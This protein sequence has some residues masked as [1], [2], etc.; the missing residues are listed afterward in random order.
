ML[1]ENYLLVLFLFPFFSTLIVALSRHRAAAWVSVAMAFAFFVLTLI[2]FQVHELR[3]SATWFGNLK[4]GL[5][6]DSYSYFLILL[7]A[8]LTLISLFYSVRV[9]K[10]KVAAYHALFHALQATVVGSLLCDDLVFFYIFWEAMLIPMYFIIGIWGGPRRKYATL[11]FFL[12]TFAGSLLMLI[13]LITTYVIYFQQT[14]TWSASFQTLRDYFHM[15]PMNFEIQKWIF[16]SFVLSFAIKIP[17]FPFHT[18]LPDAHV[19][20]PTAGSVILAGVLLKM[21]TYGLMRFAIPLFHES[22]EYFAGALCFLSVV[23]IILGALVAWRQTDIKKLI[24]YSSVSHL[25]F[26]TLGIFMMTEAGWNGA[27]LQMLNHGLSTGALFLLV[28]FLYDQT[29]TRDIQ[30]YG[31]LAKS[32]P[33]FA[34]VTVIIALSSIALPGTN[35]FVGE[36]LIL[37]GSFQSKVASNGW[38]ILAGVGVILGAVYMLHLVQKLLYG[39]SHSEKLKDFGWR[40]WVFYVPLVILVFAIGIFPEWILGPVREKTTAMFNLFSTFAAR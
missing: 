25:G 5:Y 14:G 8:F 23:G 20:A 26:I 27:Y 31:G 7:S 38:V 17:L 33:W 12:F 22:A 34:L 16:L 1:N 19:E 21:G 2:G 37:L 18:W 13:G 24:A 39:K 32:L 35:G 29:H 9:I 40:E 30:A 6:L 15:N 11:K 10:E 4:Y 3:Y 28:G 36:F